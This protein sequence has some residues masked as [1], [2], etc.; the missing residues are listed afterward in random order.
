MFDS[1]FQSG[2]LDFV[3]RI[4]ENE[5][6]CFLRSDTNTKGHTNWYYFKVNNMEH[7]G[8]VKFN[9]CN[10][11]KARNLYGKGMT[12]YT[13]VKEKYNENNKQWKQNQCFQVLFNERLC[14]YGS[15]KIYNQLQFT[16]NF[17]TE[18]MEV[19]FAYSIPYTFSNLQKY[20]SEIKSNSFV[21]VETLCETFS[22]LEIPLI[23]LSNNDKK[24]KAN[25]V[26]TAR[27]HPG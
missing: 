26:I 14:K 27:I 22:G 5:Y 12:P 13:L 23:I 25:V 11:V 8:N 7:T 24:K 10:I 20:I 3:T 2:N 1:N 19:L 21:K 16:F 17:H 4:K 18:N 9:I 6:D 15:E